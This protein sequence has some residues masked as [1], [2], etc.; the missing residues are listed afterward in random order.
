M[1]DRRTQGSILDIGYY[2]RK[3][4]SDASR[5]GMF[6]SSRTPSL[7]DI[8]VVF[9]GKPGILESLWRSSCFKADQTATVDK[10]TKTGAYTRQDCLPNRYAYGA[11]KCTDFINQSV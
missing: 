3:C 7:K 11:A 9:T 5:T 6:L 10:A 2:Q 8:G 4:A 1:Q